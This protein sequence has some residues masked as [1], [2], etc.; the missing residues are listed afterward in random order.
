MYNYIKPSCIGQSR[1]NMEKLHPVHFQ[2]T[3]T[4]PCKFQVNGLK[5]KVTRV[6][7]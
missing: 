6:Q 1:P 4:Q 7:S 5:S 2:G 3:G